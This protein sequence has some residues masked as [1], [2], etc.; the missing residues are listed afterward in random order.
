M[1]GQLVR[2][3]PAIK[4]F[5]DN[6]K[7]IGDI[8]YIKIE[9][10]KP[11]TEGYKRDLIYDL[12][13]HDFDLLSY[14]FNMKCDKV[15]FVNEKNYALIFIKD[16]FPVFIEMNLLSVDD[17]RMIRVVGSKGIMDLYLAPK[18]DVIL[19]KNGLIRFMEIGDKNALLDELTHFIDCVRNN[20]KPLVTGEDG[21]KAVKTIKSL[22]GG[23]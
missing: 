23:D 14:L 7:K 20:K 10:T 11:Y 15:E 2:F 1:V 8:K 16:K 17:R 3:N 22:G 6:K 19:H 4:Y 18:P 12:G 9:R 5:K 13:I 21:L